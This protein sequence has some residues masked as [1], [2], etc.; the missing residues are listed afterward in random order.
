MKDRLGEDLEIGDN[1]VHVMAKGYPDKC[2]VLG[3]TLDRDKV[4]IR[5]EYW[6]EGSSSRVSPEKLIKVSNQGDA[7]V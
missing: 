6:R 1:A 7:H 3:F 2:V 5:K 4:I